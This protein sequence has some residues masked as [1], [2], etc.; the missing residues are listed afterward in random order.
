M[1]LATFIADLAS[2]SARQ[3]LARLL[4]RL[5]QH[6]ST[7]QVLLPSR[8]DVGAMLGI[9]QV[10]TRIRAHPLCVC[11]CLFVC[12]LFLCV[13]GGGIFALT[14]VLGARCAGVLSKSER[15][16]G[17]ANTHHVE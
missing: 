6:D 12:E 9:V 8:E 17:G 1:S 10:R 11:I 3:R 4:L 16:G 7:R 15:W 2:G 13:W 14:F 5:S